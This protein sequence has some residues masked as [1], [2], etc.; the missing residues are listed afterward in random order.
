MYCLELIVGG[1]HPHQGVQ[2]I[3]G[4]DEKFPLGH[5]SIDHLAALGR[6]VSKACLVITA[7]IDPDIIKDHIIRQAI[8]DG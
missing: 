5:F 8:A 6:R 3:F 1:C 4:M 7:I 2:V